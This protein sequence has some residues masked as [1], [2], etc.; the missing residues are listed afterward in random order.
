MPQTDLKHLKARFRELYG[1]ESEFSIRAPGRVNLIGE[2]TDYNDGFVFPAAIDFDVA[3]VGSRRSDRQIRAFSEV[4]GESSTFSLD[5][6]RPATD[7]TWSNYIRGVAT[8]LEKEGRE[9]S[10]MNAVVSGTVP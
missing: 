4:Y 5:D 7:S 2:H 3:I 10:G 6:L 9:L 1:I 8:I